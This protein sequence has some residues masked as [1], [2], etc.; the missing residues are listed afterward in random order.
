MRICRIFMRIRRTLMRIRLT[1]MR[2][3]LTF[4][5][6]P[7]ANADADLCLEVK[8]FF[9]RMAS[10]EQIRFHSNVFKKKNICY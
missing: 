7:A 2:I 4:R 9:L 1:L 5:A 6:D 3:R 8:F 10:Y